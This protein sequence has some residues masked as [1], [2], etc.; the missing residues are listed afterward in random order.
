[1]LDLA[2]VPVGQEGTGKRGQVPGYR[3]FGKT[4]TAQKVDPETRAIS[5]TRYVS[6]FLAGAPAEEPRL[7]I[8][9]AV[10]EPDR[11][12]GYYGGTV[13]A[14]VARKILADA[15]PYLGVEPGGEAPA[16]SALGRTHLVQQPAVD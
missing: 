10:N 9:V 14:P 12:I 4:G 15:L 3:V 16:E 5:H 11:S 8:A 7:V 13:A 2:L 6:W 1:M